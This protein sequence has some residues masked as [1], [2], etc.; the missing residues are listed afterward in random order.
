MQINEP[1][2]SKTQR[3]ARV[4]T[5]AGSDSGGC[6]GLQADLKTFAALKTHGMCAVTAVTAQDTH[7]VHSSFT[8]PKE[9]IVQQ[10]QIVASDI[11]VDGVKTGM[12]P[13][14]EI[15]SCVA[16]QLE[17]LRLERLVV[18]PVMITSG[19]NRLVES[20]A[21]RQM[22]SEL[23]PISAVV[24]P[25]VH[26]AEVLVGRKLVT[27]SDFKRAAEEIRRMGP[28]SVVIKGGHSGDPEH[29]VDIFFDGSDFHLLKGRRIQ[30]VNTHGGGCTFAAAIAAYLARGF[31][32]LESVSKAKEYVQKA[33]QHSFSLGKGRGPLGHFFATE[34]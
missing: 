2:P 18:D 19:G 17:L 13:S 24:T 29:S 22:V 3:F 5:I 33:I 8:L 10:I 28:K 16:E 9:M 34:E 30:T 20:D 14:A 4:L 25:N 21:V 31:S 12:L 15:V 7:T 27:E 26:E 1:N 23:L 32:R 11:G 6:A